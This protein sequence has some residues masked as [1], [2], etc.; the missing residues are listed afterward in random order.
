MKKGL[1]FGIILLLFLNY[2]IKFVFPE[3]EIIINYV[4]ALLIVLIST[5]LLFSFKKIRSDI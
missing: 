5:I 4:T 1:L 2:I 3:M